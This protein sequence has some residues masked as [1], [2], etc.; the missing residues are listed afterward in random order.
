MKI[1]K[2]YSEMNSRLIMDDFVYVDCTDMIIQFISCLSKTNFSLFPNY[3]SSDVL[4]KSSLTDRFIKYNEL[5]KYFD[6]LF[7]FENHPIIQIYSIES[8]KEFYTCKYSI[9]FKSPYTRRSVLLDITSSFV[10][11]G[12]HICCLVD[13]FEIKNSFLCKNTFLYTLFPKRFNKKIQLSK[14]KILNIVHS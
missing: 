7:N 12:Y 5:K 1:V 13:D 9:Q 10:F 11:K 14:Q 6:F 4:Y 3:F 2:T 8:F